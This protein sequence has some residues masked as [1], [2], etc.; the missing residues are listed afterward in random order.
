VDQKKRDNKTV[1]RKKKTELGGKKKGAEE[2][3]I[4]WPSKLTPGEQFHPIH[5]IPERDF[6]DGVLVGAGSLKPSQRERE[7]Q[8]VRVCQ[9]QPFFGWLFVAKMK[10]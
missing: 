1:A 6:L 7:R 3:K 2:K 8:C 10:Y 4:Y 5:E 9:R